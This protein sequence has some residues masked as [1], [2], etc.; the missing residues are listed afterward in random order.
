[1][2]ETMVAEAAL[3]PE[4]RQ[5]V[6]DALDQHSAPARVEKVSQLLAEG[7]VQAALENIM[8]SELF[9]IVQGFVG[10]RQDQRYA[11]GR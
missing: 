4:R 11:A 8:P 2:R 6:L 7:R 10:N 5:L 1:M 9:V 3:N